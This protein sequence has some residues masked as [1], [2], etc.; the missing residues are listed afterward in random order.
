MAT[1]FLLDKPITPFWLTQ[2]LL[3]AM[4]IWGNL[5]S[6]PTSLLAQQSPSIN[7]AKHSETERSNT[8]FRFQDLLNSDSGI[9]F[10]FSR[11][12]TD[13]PLPPIVAGDAM[14]RRSERELDFDQPILRVDSY[15]KDLPVLQRPGRTGNLGVPPSGRGYYSFQDVL[16]QRCRDQPPPQ[17]YPPFALMAPSFFDVNWQFLDDIEGYW[18]WSDDLKRQQLGSR[19][20]LT[21][22]GSAW[23]RH[24]SETNSRLSGVN[25][26]FDLI[27]TRLFADLSYLDR[28]RFYVEYIDAHR[29]NGILPPLPIEEN[30]SDF[31][32]LFV[33]VR[34]GEGR[35]AFAAP[36][37]ARLG[38]QELNMGSQRLVSTLDW[39]NTRRTFQGVRFFNRNDQRDIDLWWSQPV[40]ADRSSLDEVDGNQHFV[41]AWLTTRPS[42]QVVWDH[43]YLF[44][45]NTDPRPEFGQ[46]VDGFNLHTIGSRVLGNVDRFHYD[47]EF[48]GQLGNRGD[49]DIVAGAV[50]VGHGLHLP[51]L[52]WNPTLWGYYDFASGDPSPGAGRHTT[53]NPLF[54]FGHYYNGYLD[55]VGRQNLHDL[56]LHL[57]S[58]PKNWISMQT[59]YHYLTLASSQ[60]A[61]YNVAGIPVRID[62]SGNAGRTIG[63]E[64][65]FLI[66]F[67]MNANL[68]ILVGY[69]KLYEGR[70]IRETGPGTSPEL[71]YLQT[72][73]R[74]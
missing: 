72:N 24:V 12:P 61:L 67:H 55:I 18:S 2:S 39:A 30:R 20:L 3:L 6:L 22:G 43:Y 41:G 68:D 59:Q 34:L 19:W 50:S 27:R 37:Y 65:D 10:D 62:P 8:A 64:V 53:F 14:S 38:R 36:W 4:T 51:G 25:Q 5:L 26:D 54:P 45:S 15:W 49:Q 11:S 60:D 71:F 13:L 58:N 23:W 56:N 35:N 28:F 9:E 44:L 47:Y 46:P 16:R 57:N 29:F 52:P 73:Y 63:H 31:L 7:L 48:M 40:V 69:S 21:L 42:P 32:N 66:N 70:F 1:L 74:W 17:P 33:D